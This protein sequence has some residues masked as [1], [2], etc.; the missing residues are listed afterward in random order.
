MTQKEKIL[1]AHAQVVDR[2]ADLTIHR[3]DSKTSPM[4]ARFLF[5]DATALVGEV[6]LL[7]ALHHLDE[8]SQDVVRE[9]A[10]IPGCKAN[11]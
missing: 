8:S 6:A 9:G 5:A 7:M 2:L 3:D 1:R 11:G 4:S 10:T